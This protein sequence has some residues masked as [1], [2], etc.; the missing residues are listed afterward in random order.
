MHR[1]ASVTSAPSDDGGGSVAPPWVGAEL[2]PG[3]EAK[4]EFLLR[5]RAKGVRDLAV[6]R[7]LESVPRELFAPHR[8]ADLAAKDVALPIPC[9]QTMSEPYLVARMMEALTVKPDSKVLEIGSGSGYASAVLA[10]LAL[11]VLS[12]ERYQSL[13]VQART[14]LE[15]QGISNAAVVWGDG[16]AVPPAAGLFDRLLIHAA[17]DEIPAAL[18]DRMCEGAILVYARTAGSRQHLMRAVRSDDGGLVE[19]VVCPSRLLPLQR[20]LSQGL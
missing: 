16:L 14:R 13:A 20:G 18:R 9:G 10:R 6:L 19:T 4:A 8:Y 17:V 15:A 1:P 11:E 12:I 7:A 3:A 2:K 5:L